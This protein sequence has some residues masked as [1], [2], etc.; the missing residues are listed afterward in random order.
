MITVMVTI[1]MIIIPKTIVMTMMLVEALKTLQR[2]G[3][4]TFIYFFCS[5]T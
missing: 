5:E 1:I 3:A 2:E 4:S